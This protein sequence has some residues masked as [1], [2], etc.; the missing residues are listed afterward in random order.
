MENINAVQTETKENSRLLVAEYR[1]HA[2]E[3]G[4]EALV[5]L[6]HGDTVGAYYAARNA[7]RYARWIEEEIA[8]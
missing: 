8:N 2:T 3:S 7:G 5:A 6:I 1:N 4:V